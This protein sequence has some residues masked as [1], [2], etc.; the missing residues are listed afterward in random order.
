MFPSLRQKLRTIRT[1]GPGEKKLLLEATILPILI[2][3][4]F[5][6][7]GVS[8]TQAM[9]RRWALNRKNWQSSV[10]SW[11]EIQSARRAQQIVKSATGLEGTCLVRSLA[12]WGLLLGRGTSTELR[13][14][15][16]K[17][18]GRMQGHAWLEHDGTPINEA[19]ET[20]KTYS[21]YEGPL[22]FDMFGG[23]KKAH[24]PRG[25]RL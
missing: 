12:L 19:P 11:S 14:G 5:R 8:R 2:A 24:A 6:V 21:A 15:M 22:S 20:V 10:D 25:M 4:G 9:L 16:R 18:D 17:R 23:T 3:A 13:V 1:L 7:A